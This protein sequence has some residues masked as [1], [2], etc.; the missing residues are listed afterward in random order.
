MDNNKELNKK[1][2]ALV[3]LSLHSLVFSMYM[4]GNTMDQICKNLHIHKTRV[5]E[6]LKGLEKNRQTNNK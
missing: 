4:S 3:D 5:V 6:L 1:L 2:D